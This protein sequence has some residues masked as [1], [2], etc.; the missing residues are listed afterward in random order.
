MKSSD[1]EK[2]EEVLTSVRPYLNFPDDL[3]EIVEEQ[4]EKS[5]NLEEFEKQFEKLISEQED[6]TS[7]AD[8]RI[9]L[10]KLQSR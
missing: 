3:R 2:L 4:A 5:S 8:Y 7:Q 9:F 10:N 1:K 6:P